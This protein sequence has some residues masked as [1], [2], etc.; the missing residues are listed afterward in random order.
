MAKRNVAPVKK[1]APKTKAKPAAPKS[2]GTPK[3]RAK[4]TPKARTTVRSLV[5]AVVRAAG[6]VVG[7]ATR[8]TTPA[9]AKSK[10]AKYVYYFGDGKADGDRTTG[11]SAMTM[12]SAKNVVTAGPRAAP[13][14]NALR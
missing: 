10:A 4:A 5:K 3:A 13:S 7:K 12:T 11:S 1:S 14:L 2:K 8:A 6:K 9:K